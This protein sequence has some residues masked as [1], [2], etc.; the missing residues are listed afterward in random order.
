MKTISALAFVAAACALAGSGSAASSPRLTLADLPEAELPGLPSLDRR[1]PSI[2]ASSTVADLHVDGQAGATPQQTRGLSSLARKGAAQAAPPPVPG[3]QASVTGSATDAC[4]SVVAHGRETF[5]TTQI[6]LDSSEGV[7]PVRIESVKE[8]AGTAEL[9]ILDVWVDPVTHGAQEIKRQI[10]PLKRAAS[11]PLGAAA[12]AYRTGSAVT[13]VVPAGTSSQLVDSEGRFVTSS[14][15]VA[16]GELKVERGKGTTLSGFFTRMT[17]AQ[18][19]KDGLTAIPPMPIRIG[20]SASASQLSADPDPV[21]S[22][23]LRA[24]DE[25][26][27]QVQRRRGAAAPSVDPE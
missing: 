8:N 12:Y 14:C 26:P 16:R 9:Q 6:F 11:G 20:L 21:L 2:P 22:V 23:Q 17:A 10:V 5:R 19:A 25:V 27:V 4:V 13:L 24:L 3:V 15:Q 1:P 18:D 7:L